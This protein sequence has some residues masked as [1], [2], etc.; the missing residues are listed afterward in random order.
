MRES[1]ERNLQA[2]SN[3]QGPISSAIMLYAFNE[4]LKVSHVLG[5]VGQKMQGWGWPQSQVKLPGIL[6]MY[7]YP[8]N[9]EGISVLCHT[10]N[11]QPL[12]KHNATREVPRAYTRRLIIALA[13]LGVMASATAHRCGRSLN[14][15]PR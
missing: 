5:S 7:G 2:S 4:S 10:Y 6:F 9:I 8:P 1:A 14:Q 13:A 11:S 12:L 3:K 15:V